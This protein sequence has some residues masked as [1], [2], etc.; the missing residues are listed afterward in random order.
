MISY[1]IEATDENGERV[2]IELSE[3]NLYFLLIECRRRRFRFLHEVLE[4]GEYPVL[5]DFD[6]KNDLPEN[7]PREI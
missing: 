7:D 4:W 6:P 2:V 3:L 1:T 5:R